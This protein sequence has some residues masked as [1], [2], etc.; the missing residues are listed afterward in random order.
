MVA[1][2]SV[3]RIDILTLKMRPL[4]CLKMSGTSYPVM[5]HHSRRRLYSATPLQK[6]EN[7]MNFLLLEAT[8]S[9][10]VIYIGHGA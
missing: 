1:S 7:A 10:K 3:V 5:W 4:S 6:R 9:E 2:S 8:P